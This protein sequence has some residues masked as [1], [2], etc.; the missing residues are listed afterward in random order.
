MPI[1]TASF[2]AETRVVPPQE[3]RG[4]PL[5]VWVGEAP[6]EQENI[7]GRPFVGKVGIDFRWQLKGAG[8]DD[9]GEAIINVARQRFPNNE[10]EAVQISAGEFREKFPG[11]LN[12]LVSK[13]LKREEGRVDQKFWERLCQTSRTVL[14][15]P[16]GKGY[17][18]PE[19]WEDVVYLHYKILKWDPNIIICLGAV[20]I[21]AIMG[22]ASPS[23]EMFAGHVENSVLGIKALAT[24][25]PGFITR[26][27]HMRFVQLCH[28]IHAKAESKKVE[29]EY[30]KRL[31]LVPT[32]IQDV[33]VIW[34]LQREHKEFPVVTDIETFPFYEVERQIIRTVGFGFGGGKVALVIPF[35]R[36]NG[37]DNSYWTKKEEIE[38]H[39]ELHRFYGDPNIEFCGQNGGYDISWL[40]EVFG[41]R[42]V[43]Y[44][45]DTKIQAFVLRPEIP[46]SLR[47]LTGIYCPE[48]INHKAI[49]GDHGMEGKFDG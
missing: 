29:I 6:G 22:K 46:K 34:R 24:Y 5:R 28:I 9:E 10:E 36:F 17:L 49:K 20:A 16:L 1:K 12:L 19:L 31:V 11:G 14:S 32:S 7:L 30:G 8:I 42:V 38:V 25:H 48:L 47:L 4:R 15:N 45:H 2:V 21:W 33:K 3:P 40:W 23:V 43:N 35:F 27:Y 26:Q 37:K 41:I 13:V 44:R 18:K 39:K